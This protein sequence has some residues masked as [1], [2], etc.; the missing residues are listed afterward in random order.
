MKNLLYIDA[1]NLYRHSM[2]QVLP[3]DETEIWHGHPDL[4]MK[5]GI[6]KDKY[7]DYMNKTKPKKFTKLK[8]LVCGWS[9]KKK[10]QILYRMLKF[11]V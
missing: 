7:N 5:K 11:R 10:F 3:Y 2:S 4:Y 9:D 1:T 6:L 8:K